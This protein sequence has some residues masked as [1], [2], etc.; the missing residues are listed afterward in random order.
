MKKRVMVAGLAGMLVLFA[1][2][3][4]Y[5][6]RWRVRTLQPV[7]LK[8]AR[9]MMR[10]SAEVGEDVRRVTGTQIYEAKN[11]TGQTLD[12]L[13][14]RLYPNAIWDGSLLVGSVTVDGEEASF[15][16]DPLDP[17]VLRIRTSWQSGQTHVFSW[18]FALTIPPGEGAISR[19]N[20][21]ALCVGALPVPALFEGGAWR[22]DA[23]NALA[24]TLGASKFDYEMT[25][26]APKTVKA[27]FGGA[28]VDYARTDGGTVWSVQ[29]EGAMDMPFALTTA[30]AV[31]ME[32]ADGMLLTAMAQTP[33]Q[34]NGLLRQARKA[35]QSLEELGLPYPARALC[36]VQ[37]DTQAQDGLIG[38]GMIVL[39]READAQR[40]LSRMTVLIARQTFGVAAQNDPWNAP[41][42]SI[43]LASSAEMIAYRHSKGEGAY[44]RRFDEQIE[45]ASRL[46]RPH[47]VCVGAP[48]DR[49]GSDT[50]MM[51]VLRDQGAAMM[52]GI[53]RAVGEETYLEAMRLYVLRAQD[54]LAD[55]TLLEEALADATGYR[56]DGYLQDGLNE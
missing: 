52:L 37:A 29:G 45:I 53:E 23:Y 5:A 49:F 40:A 50:E 46:T 4:C 12:E 55:R 1:A 27:A 43:S 56:W 20:G 11:T 33:Y 48:V 8:G 38:S 19:A 42:L 30:C 25:L 32:Q 47:G 24:G 9:G 22:T 10:V 41:W 7:A 28:L 14:L 18:H 34:A 31:R 17:T 6:L 54:R 51:Q 39:P 21:A 2:L 15:L 35:L 3:A 16:Q 44:E 26:S 13:V 36:A